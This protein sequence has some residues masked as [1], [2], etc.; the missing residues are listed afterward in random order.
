MAVTGTPGTGKTM[1]CRELEKM[2]FPVIYLTSYLDEK[3][4]LSER[5]VNA[6]TWLV[7]MKR[8]REHFDK[9]KE[10]QS[11]RWMI[12]DSHLSHY[13]EVDAIV[14]LRCHPEVLRERLG[15]R[16]YSTKKINENVECE[17][18]DVIAS[19]VR[20]TPIPAIEIDTTHKK[21]E[22][23]ADDIIMFIDSDAKYDDF[24]QPCSVDWLKSI[25]Q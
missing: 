13:L 15:C 2:G 12:V 6:D 7:D 16:N 3:K 9:K 23:V 10:L 19:E 21:P 17:M 20:D 11:K 5:D 18:V 22:K 25:S 14:L 1:V 24:Q 4:L 8:V